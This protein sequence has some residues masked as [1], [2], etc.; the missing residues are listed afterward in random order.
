MSTCRTCLRL[1]K[2]SKQ[3]Q[4]DLYSNSSERLA[5]DLDHNSP[6]N[7]S[8]FS[9]S[10]MGSK[11]ELQESPLEDDEKYKMKLFVMIIFA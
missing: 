11:K 5:T 10:T 3:E 1:S 9:W 2:I 8:R 6:I 7:S 4:S